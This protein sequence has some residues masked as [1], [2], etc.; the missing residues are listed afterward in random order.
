MAPRAD[1]IH[2]TG[3]T[4]ALRSPTFLLSGVPLGHR[5]IKAG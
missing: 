2:L 5:D 3:F 1:H 4:S